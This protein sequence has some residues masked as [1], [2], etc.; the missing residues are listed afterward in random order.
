VN[1]EFNYVIAGGILIVLL[2]ITVIVWILFGKKIR[3]YFRLK[4]LRREYDRFNSQ[5]NTSLHSI[6]MEQSIQAA[7]HSIVL[8]KRYLETLENKPYTK[9]TSRET[10]RLIPNEQIRQS[11]QGIDRMLYANASA[12]VQPFEHLRSYADEAFHKKVK[13]VSHG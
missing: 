11:L 2:F 6:G 12:D 3:R 4:Q 13:E 7:E 10:F 9:L 8:W 1:K 5:F